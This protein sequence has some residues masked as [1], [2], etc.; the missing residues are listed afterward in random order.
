[1]VALSLYFDLDS[2]GSFNNYMVGGK[3]NVNVTQNTQ[4]R[5]GSFKT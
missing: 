3:V 2:V 4:I 1:M 5:N